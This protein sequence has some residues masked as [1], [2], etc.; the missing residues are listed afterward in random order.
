LQTA[1][2]HL[3]DQAA[4]GDSF[5]FQPKYIPGLMKFEFFLKSVLSLSLSFSQKWLDAWNNTVTLFAKMA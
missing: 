3:E 4:W 2:P 5:Q 1:H